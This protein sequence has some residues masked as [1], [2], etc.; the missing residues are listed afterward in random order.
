MKYIKIA[1]VLTLL[2]MMVGPVQAHHS[3]A[4]FDKARVVTIKGTMGKVEWRNPHVIMMVNVTDE[5]GEVTQYTVECNSPNVMLRNGWKV[6]TLK[7][8]DPVSAD[9]YPLRDGRPGGLLDTV[10]LS[11]GTKIKG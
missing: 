9:L 6:S 5:K 1:S 11:N 4:M 3:F 8:G 7:V 2:M 10:T